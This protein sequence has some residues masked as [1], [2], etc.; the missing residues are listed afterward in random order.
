[1][2]IYILF[3]PMLFLLCSCFQGQP[4]NYPF[5][6][7]SNVLKEKFINDKDKKSFDYTKPELEEKPGYL[8]IYLQNNIDFFLVVLTAIKLKKQDEKTSQIMIRIN[9]HNRQWNYSLRKE[10][11][12]KDF[13][14]CLEDRLKTGKWKNLPWDIKYKRTKDVF[15]FGKKTTQ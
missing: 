8:Y 9:E 1:M 10:Q 12:E 11:M 5:D 15:K 7:V 4:I 14:K 13:F 6:E 3:I 2:K